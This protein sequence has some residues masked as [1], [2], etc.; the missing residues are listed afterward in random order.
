M[1]KLLLLMSMGIIVLMAFSLSTSTTYEISHLEVEAFSKTCI[2]DKY[3]IQTDCCYPTDKTTTT[4]GHGAF[5]AV[6]GSSYCAANGCPSGTSEC[7]A[8]Q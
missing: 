8:K 7:G 4:V 2:P 5:C 6:G 1:K 3:P